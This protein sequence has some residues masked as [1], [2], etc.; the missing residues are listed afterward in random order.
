MRDFIVIGIIGVALYYGSRVL[1]AKK[2]GDKSVVRAL[3]PRITKTDGN[4]IVVRFD[5]AVD[6]PTNTTVRLSKP[7]IT[8]TSQGKYIVSSVPENKSYLIAPLSQTSLEASEI[9]IPWITLS[10][11][12]ADMLTKSSFL[13]Q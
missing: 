3:N 5:V 4:G 10:S 8:L 12:L 9:T 6:N 13:L 2:I 7:I 11:Y 1:G